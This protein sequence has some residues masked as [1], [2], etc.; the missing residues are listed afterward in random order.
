MKPLVLLGALLVVVTTYE[1]LAVRERRG[2]GWSGGRS[3][4]FACG[5]LVA[6]VAVSPAFDERADADFGMHGAQHL[7]LAMVAPLGLVL[8][9]PLTLLLRQLPH[10]AARRLGR[11][12]GS[13]PV[14]LLTRPAVALLLSSGGLVVLYFT[15]L[16]ELSTDHEAVHRLVHLH[17]VAAG[18][19][20]AWVIAGPDPT[21]HRASVRVRLVVLGLA[22]A[23]HASVAQ[24]L[25]AGIG[26]QVREPVH[27]MRAAGN[28][29]YFGG[30]I[31]E[32]TLAL[33]VLLTWRSRR[34]ASHRSGGASRTGARG[35]PEAAA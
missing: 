14:R 4:T 23:V 21:P 9:A 20:F 8:A 30:D 12:L 33:V 11:A 31:A 28:L 10:R 32:L 5:V 17:L 19:L 26:V 27:Q 7:L 13:W 35:G 29:M 3:V 18:T 1:V 24:M 15:P 6:G 22:V 16:Y 2:R 34:A 25:Y